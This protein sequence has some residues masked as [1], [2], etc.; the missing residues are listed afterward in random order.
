MQAHRVIPPDMICKDKF[1]IE[2][3]MVVAGTTRENI[4]S[5]TVPFQYF[6]TI[7]SSWILLIFM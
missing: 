5:A 2:C 1:L 3:A 7:V 4:T 6:F